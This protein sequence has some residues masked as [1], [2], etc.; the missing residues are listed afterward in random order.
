MTSQQNVSSQQTPS[1]FSVIA[2]TTDLIFDPV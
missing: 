2:P 1:T